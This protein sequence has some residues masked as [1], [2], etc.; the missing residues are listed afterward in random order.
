MPTGRSALCIIRVKACSH[1]SKIQFP[2]LIEAIA[3]KS[4]SLQQGWGCQNALTCRSHPSTHNRDRHAFA[5]KG[6]INQIPIKSR[7]AV[8]SFV[9]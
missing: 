6:L 4:G 5:K 1:R 7:T 3:Q 2:L 8:A 9:G